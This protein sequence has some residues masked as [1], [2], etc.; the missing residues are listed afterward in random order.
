MN[1]KLIRI[2]WNTFK[3]DICERFHDL[4]QI[5]FPVFIM[6]GVIGMAVKF[7]SWVLGLGI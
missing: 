7:W 3:I 4:M 1:K 5:A 2:K 6:T